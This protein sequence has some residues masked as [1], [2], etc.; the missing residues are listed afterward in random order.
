M[1]AVPKTPIRSLLLCTRAP[2]P[3]IGGDRLRTFQ[4]A[5]ALASLGPVRV[6]SAGSAEPGQHEGLGFAEDVVNLP[7][8]RLGTAAR[9]GRAAFH[10]QPL[11]QAL[12]DAPALRR[13]V[14]DA[15][16]ETDVVVAHLL[17][18][19]A[20]LPASRPPLV[21][22]LQDALAAQAEEASRSPGWTG[23]W[24]RL[25]LRVEQRRLEE[26]EITAGRGA[27]RVTAITERDR[28]LLVAAGLD[29]NRITVVPAQVERIASQPG[30]PEPDT[31]VF[32]GN[33]RTA[34]NRDMAVHLAR[35]ILPMVRT[36]RRTVRLRIVGIEAAREVTRLGTLPGVDIV[37]PVDD[38]HEV[39]A[40]AW[41]TACPL[42]F[43]SGVQNK[44]LESLAAGTPAVVTPRVLETLDSAASSALRVGSHDRA[45]AVGL[46]GLLA[47][48]EARDV[49]GAAG[50]DFVRRYHGP[51]ALRPLLDAVHA[52]S[53]RS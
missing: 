5:R 9:V 4:I 39:L 16:P 12:Y 42:R 52:L 23:G 11:Q 7:L 18:T 24:R 10:N 8:P 53:P 50:L 25:A 19:V 38:M 48:R 43:G 6:I 30:E 41:V 3:P 45:L 33:L 26:A 20:W 14:A 22:C 2:W 44:V 28:D 37:G 1:I 49:A 15:L 17:R 29:G 32:A 51:D 47:D 21:L 13:A 34:S 36:Q 40:R 46:L 35:R 27:D 31:I